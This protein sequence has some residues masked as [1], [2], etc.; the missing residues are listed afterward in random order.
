MSCAW[1]AKAPLN[2][3]GKEWMLY[4]PFFLYSLRWPIEVC[5]YEQKTF[6]YLFSYMLRSK[7]GIELLVNLINISYCSMKIIPFQENEFNSYCFKSVQD[8]HFFLS[9]KI[10]RQIFLSDFSQNLE[11]CFNSCYSFNSLKSSIFKLIA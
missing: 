1:Q 6:W 8:F 7:T 3:T 9:E 5:F 4:I 2:Y 10:K 11:I